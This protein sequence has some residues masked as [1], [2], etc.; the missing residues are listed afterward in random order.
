MVSIFRIKRP[1]SV[2]C[3][4]TRLARGSVL[5]SPFPDESID[6][7]TSLCVFYHRRVDNDLQGIREIR[8][9]LKPGWK[10]F[11]FDSATPGLY[12]NHDRVFHGA[13]RYTKRELVAKLEMAGFVVDLAFYANCMLTPILFIK[14][15]FE[16][17]FRIDPRSDVIVAN[18]F[19]NTLV[20]F[21]T[22]L[23]M[24]V[25]TKIA[26]PFRINIVTHSSKGR[27]QQENYKGAEKKRVSVLTILN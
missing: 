25:S 24:L 27:P 15:Q 2:E 14:R 12:G 6:L 11:L 4:D 20:R 26:L 16:E 21:L 13:R 1:I 18:C 8:R 17:F 10:I 5:K 23:D 19:L 7:I 9:V 22:W 3:R